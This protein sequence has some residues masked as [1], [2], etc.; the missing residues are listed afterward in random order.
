MTK[1]PK[2]ASI[3]GEA[4]LDEAALD[5]L[6][7]EALLTVTPA[8][9]TFD[10]EAVIGAVTGL[11]PHFRD[12]V[13]PTIFVLSTDNALLTE[14]EAR[15]KADPEAMLPPSLRIAVAAAEVV[16]GRSAFEED[17]PMTRAFLS[18]ITAAYPCRIVN[19]EGADP[20]ARP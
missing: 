20:L 10:A 6:M 14:F 8:K 19:D 2:P 5:A 1:A 9:G 3:A 15:R 16:V 17:G 4:T 11:G 12:P 7:A 13:D 18:W